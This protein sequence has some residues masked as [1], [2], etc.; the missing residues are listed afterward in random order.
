MLVFYKNWFI[1]NIIYLDDL[2]NEYSNFYKFYEF[3]VKY[4]FDVFFI[5][6][7]GFIDVIF[8]VWKDKIKW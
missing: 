6:F 2:L 3:K 7:Y 4:N 8:N 1:Y 5:V